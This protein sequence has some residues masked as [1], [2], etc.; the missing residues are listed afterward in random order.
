MSSFY[1]VLVS[2]YHVYYGNPR[3]VADFRFSHRLR[4]CSKPRVVP[5][6]FPVQCLASLT[7]FF[8]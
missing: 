4:L 3:S 7:S 8:M 1:G 2:T 6:T 5:K